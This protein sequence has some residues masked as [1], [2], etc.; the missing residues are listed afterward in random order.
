MKNF[1]SIILLAFCILEGGVAGEAATLHSRTAAPDPVNRTVEEW[2]EFALGP[3]FDVPGA[4]VHISTPYWDGTWTSGTA[5]LTTGRPITEV[6][7]FRIA[8][9][10]KTFTATVVLQLVD[11]GVLSLED[12]LDRFG[13]GFGLSFAGLI[14]IRQL[15]NHTSGVADW[16]GSTEALDDLC[17]CSPPEALLLGYT[18]QE[19]VDMA[20]SLGPL[21]PPGGGWEYS[22]TNYI[23]LGMVIE[24]A[25]Q[26]TVTG[27]LLPEV[28]E[29][30]ILTPL[31]LDHTTYP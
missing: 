15:L 23:L 25:L 5:D 14:T 27:T 9:I 31:A 29:E 11:E 8:S 30:R 13:N 24:W 26:S 19:M 20:V 6:D 4:I 18:P 17:S 10:S 21:W 2:L 16:S 3:H 12:T 22:D 28:I 1:L 7:T